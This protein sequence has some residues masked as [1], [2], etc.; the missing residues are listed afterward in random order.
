MCNED[1]LLH[2][3][4]DTPGT[5]IE[6]LSLGD[7]EL[8]KVISSDAFLKQLR[9]GMKDCSE[10][11]INRAIQGAKYSLSPQSEDDSDSLCLYCEELLEDCVCEVED[12]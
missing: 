9:E 11:E 2:H 8:L 6:S 3:S 1:R 12:D 5:G 7:E 4:G 10:D